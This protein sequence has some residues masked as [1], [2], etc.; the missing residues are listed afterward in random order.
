MI[1][2]LIEALI[3]E[4]RLKKDLY[5]EF[6]RSFSACIIEE[7]N[8]SAAGVT[9]EEMANSALKSAAKRIERST[10]QKVD[11]KKLDAKGEDKELGSKDELDGEEMQDDDAGTRH[12]NKGQMDK[13]KESLEK[14]RKKDA[15]NEEE[16]RK[17]SF[18]RGSDAGSILSVGEHTI[19]LQQVADLSEARKHKLSSKQTMLSSAIENAATRGTDRPT[20]VFTYTILKAARRRRGLLLFGPGLLWLRLTRL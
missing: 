9:L 14:K 7:D 5:E 4:P 19:K 15:D 20:P 11:N 2:E 16:K 1:L 13:G 18:K 17:K 10:G 6:N 8:A 12:G 3:A